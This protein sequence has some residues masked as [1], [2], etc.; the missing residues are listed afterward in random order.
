MS[1]RLIYFKNYMHQW[2]VY[3]CGIF[4][5][6]KTHDNSFCQL[7]SNGRGG[8]GTGKFALMNTMFV[9]DICYLIYV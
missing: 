5:F 9:L 7:Y 6:F 1:F 3:A 8:G 2:S 4:N